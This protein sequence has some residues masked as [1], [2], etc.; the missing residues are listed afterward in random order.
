MAAFKKTHWRKSSILSYGSARPLSRTHQQDPLTVI[1]R[2]VE[3]LTEDDLRAIADRASANAR[4]LKTALE[5][6]P[7]RYSETIIYTLKNDI[8]RMVIVPL[9]KR[10]EAT[11]EQV[12]GDAY[13]AMYNI[14]EELG[15]R[16]VE[17]AREPIASAIATALADNS[18]HELDQVMIDI[19]D[20]DPFRRKLVAYFDAFVTSDFFQEL[21]E[22]NST[23]KLRENFETYLYLCEL[24]FNRVLLP[25]LL[26]ARERRA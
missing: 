11:L 23:L 2:Q 8:V 12:R 7:E 22:L 9:L 26:P 1:E 25:A 18:F 6:D 15:E 5:N 17:A 13:E 3:V 20:P 14:E 4:E 19:V 16:L 21:H 24:R 10:L